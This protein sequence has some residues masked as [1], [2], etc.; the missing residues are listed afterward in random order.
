MSESESSSSNS[1]EVKDRD[2]ASNHTQEQCI[3]GEEDEAEYEAKKQLKRKL[4]KRSPV[5]KRKNSVMQLKFERKSRRFC[6][7]LPNTNF[8]AFSMDI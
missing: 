6:I 3:S 7:R 2:A 5:A 4:I 8:L 1:N